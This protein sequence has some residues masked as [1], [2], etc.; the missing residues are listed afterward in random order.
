MTAPPPREVQHEIDVQAPAET[1]YRLIADVEQWPRIFPP[2]VHVQVLG[3]TDRSERLRIWASAN[4]ELKEWTSRRELDPDGLRIDFRQEVPAPPVAA[5][6]GAWVLEPL[7]ADAC[8][9]TLLHDYRAKDDDPD[10]LAWIDRAVDRNSRSELAALKRN[11]ELTAERSDLLLTFEDTVQVEGSA[12]DVYDFISEAQLWAQR[13]PHVDS[14][15]LQ[16]RTPGHQRLQMR[17]RA[18][19]GSL[20]TT[21][22]YRVCLPHRQIVYKQIQVPAL[23]NLHTGHWMLT[24]NPDGVAVTSR[25]TVVLREDT[26]AGVLGEGAGV[27]QARTFV[28]E[29]LGANSLATIGHARQYAAERAGDRVD[30][31][32][33]RPADQAGSGPA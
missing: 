16:E 24:E 33:G 15:T 11:V 32:A 22:S 3:R 17:T 5:M 23:M 12:R 7:G 4:D 31:P 19:D 9:V 6:G 20:H 25:H 13:L 18:K 29:A 21:T 27:P 28:R 14:V 10:H 26:I 2:T 8:R 30:Q 1:V